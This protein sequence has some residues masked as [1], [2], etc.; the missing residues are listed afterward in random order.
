MVKVGDSDCS[1]R[2]EMGDVFL[3]DKGENQHTSCTIWW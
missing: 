1:D 2:E 3:P